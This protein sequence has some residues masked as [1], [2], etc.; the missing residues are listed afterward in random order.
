LDLAKGNQRLGYTE[1]LDDNQ[2]PTEGEAQ[3]EGEAPS[4]RARNVMNAIDALP[5]NHR[6]ALLAK[7]GVSTESCRGMA[8]RVSVTPQTICNWATK[9]A[10][11]VR[12][13]L[14]DKS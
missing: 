14:G 13:Q 4:E 9:A 2:A 7:A 12:G 1:N 8:R 3:T 10:G 5:A 6:D 11:S